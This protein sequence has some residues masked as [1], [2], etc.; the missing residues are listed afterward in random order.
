MTGR[1]PLAPPHTV[2]PPN[3][4][5][6][7]PSRPVPSE[8]LN[9]ALVTLLATMPRLDGL[10][11]FDGPSE[12][13]QAIVVD[14]DCSELSPEERGLLLAAWELG[15]SDLPGVTLAELRHIHGRP[16][17]ALCMLLVALDAG[18]ETLEAWTALWSSTIR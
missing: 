6:A 16:L 7:G 8:L 1:S 11:S 10:W 15:V 9:R 3:P 5:G 14:D 17:R 12:R 2:V 4:A 13:V 18:A